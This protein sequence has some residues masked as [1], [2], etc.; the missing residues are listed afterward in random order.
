[1]DLDRVKI[2]LGDVWHCF[3][4][5]F[6]DVLHSDV[7][8]LNSVNKRILDNGGKQLRPLLCLLSGKAC[9]ELTEL[10]VDCAVT[11]ELIH[12]AT[13]LHD[14]VADNSSVRRGAPTVMSLFG[15]SVSVLIGDYWLSKAIA[16]LV[17]NAGNEIILAFSTAL[18]SLARGEMLQLQKA[19]ECDTEMEDYLK[20]ISCKTAALFRAA[21]TSG[22]Y[23]VKAPGKYVKAMSDYAEY[24]GLAF[25]MR[26]DIFDYVPKMDVGKK[27]GV[28]ILEQKITLPLI[29]ALR[30]SSP[31]KNAEIRGMVRDIAEHN[32]YKD[33]I[34]DFV[35]ASS[36]VARAEETLAGYSA[37]AVE[38]L[39]ALPE[40]EE[41]SML[42]ELA[43]YV[44][45]RRV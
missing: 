31:E 26:D 44:G 16:L 18:E 8:L 1:M 3:E 21:V 20:I 33:W 23:S 12:T 11:S 17:G 27:L 13:L 19:S 43:L 39:E 40:S 41:K 30:H 22:A 29:E 2:F 35:N 32:E 38:C 6:T 24:L 28:D 10:T 4:S 15:P 25:Q 5:K 7:E 34:M 45:E 37:K 36:G 9:G 14:D 42:R